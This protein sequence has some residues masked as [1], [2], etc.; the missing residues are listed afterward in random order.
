M[1][2]QLFN[3]LKSLRL[4]YLAEHLEDFVNARDGKQPIDVIQDLICIELTERAQRSANTRMRDARLGKYRH[5]SAFDWNWPKK[6]DRAKLKTYM[7]SDPVQTKQN[8]IILGSGGLGKTMIAKNLALMAINRG[9][10]TRFI[11]ASKL[12]SDLLAAGHRLETRLRYFARID[13]LIIDELGYLSFQD[14]A[15]DLLF[16]VISRRYEHAPVIVTTNLAFKDWPKVFPG[17][18]CVAALLD[19]LIHHCEIINIEG[20]SYRRNESSKQKGS[21]K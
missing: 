6:L 14:R 17:A 13:L 5:M 3:N 4:H 11:T 7:D 20:D 9:H 1:D 2:L 21:E 8:L 18:A 19:R 16:E 12:V 15:A 10:T